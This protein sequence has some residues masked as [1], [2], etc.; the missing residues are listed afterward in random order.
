MLLLLMLLPQLVLAR[1]LALPLN[2]TWCSRAAA[3]APRT[4]GLQQRG[5]LHT[6]LLAAGAATWQRALSTLRAA[7]LA[8]WLCCCVSVGGSPQL[9]CIP[10]HCRVHQ[11]FSADTGGAHVRRLD[12]A[13]AAAW[14][15]AQ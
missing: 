10:R 14:H 2:C 6:I 4:H 3:L 15:D 7:I 9:G 11:G 8:C 5:L 1:L 12:T 13:C